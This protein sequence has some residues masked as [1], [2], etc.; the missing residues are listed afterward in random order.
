M[1]NS[2]ARKPPSSSTASRVPIATPAFAPADRP[3]SPVLGW[4]VGLTPAELPVPEELLKGWS[5]G[6]PLGLL[7]AVG[8]GTVGPCAAVGLVIGERDV[9]QIICSLELAVSS[10]DRS[11]WYRRICIAGTKPSD[12]D[13]EVVAKPTQAPSWPQP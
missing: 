6:L 11:D 8:P 5:I 4:S 9:V 13:L 7:V 2:Q 1:C 10:R 12:W 3:P